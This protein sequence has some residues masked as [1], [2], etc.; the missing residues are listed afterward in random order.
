MAASASGSDRAPV[1]ICYDG[2]VEAAE[3]LEFVA[4]TGKSVWEP[5]ERVAHETNARLIACGTAKSGAKATVPSVL[6]QRAGPKGQQA[7]AGGALREGGRGAAAGVREG[8]IHC[9]GARPRR[10]RMSAVAWSRCPWAPSGWSSATS[11][12]ARSTRSTPSSPPSLAP[13]RTR[14]ACTASSRNVPEALRQAGRYVERAIDAQDA[15]YFLSRITVVRTDRPVMRPWRKRLFVVM[16]R[17]E[18]DPSRD[19]RWGI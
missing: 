4:E 16:A 2:S 19:L 17:N 1:V 8:L 6:P 3:A 10:R 7:G 18:A 5:V 13:S 14:P 12:R 11:A 15:S 9:P